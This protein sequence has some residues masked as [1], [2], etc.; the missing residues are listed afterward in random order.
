MYFLRI[1]YIPRCG[2][3]VHRVRCLY[4]TLKVSLRAMRDF[5]KDVRSVLL[6]RIE[7]CG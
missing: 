1:D 3:G 4:K 6:V 7:L 5:T 2:G